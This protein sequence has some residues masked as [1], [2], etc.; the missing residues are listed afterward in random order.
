MRY[1]MGYSMHRYYSEI[2]TRAIILYDEAITDSFSAHGG[3]GKSLVVNG[4]SKL[5]NVETIDGRKFEPDERFSLQRV[6]EETDIVFFD[7]VAPRFEF[8]RFNSILTNGWDIEAKHIKSFRI[9]T[10]ESPKM[11]IA[12]NSILRTRIGNSAE[13]RQFVLELSDFYP[14]L[15]NI[16]TTPVVYTHG[17]EFFSE[18]SDDE[19]LRFDNYM[20]DLCKEYLMNGLPITIP[21]NVKRNRLLQ[22]TTKEFVDWIEERNFQTNTVYVFRDTLMDFQSRYQ[23]IT[24]AKFGIWMKL[25]S[26]INELEYKTDR[27]NSVT[28][29][30]LIPKA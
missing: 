11:I 17:C 29:F 28:I 27:I 7:D 5:R 24:S 12:S 16:T 21:Q 26:S 14:R 23:E 18:W 10:K 4:I 1:A 22:E 2:I 30:K 3:T 20:I 9:P 8:E 13:R 25:Y 15:R 19:W 6:T